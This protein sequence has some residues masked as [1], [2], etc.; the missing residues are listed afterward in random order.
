MGDD[1]DA[2]LEQ[3]VDQ[4]EDTVRQMLP[5][6]RGVLKGLGAAAIGG[7]AVGGA[8]G[9]AAGQSAAG[10]IGTES[11]P[12]DVEAASVGAQ[13]VST[14]SQYN[15]RMINVANNPYNAPKQGNGV[16]TQAVQQ[17]IDDLNGGPGV[18]V[19]PYWVAVEGLDLT[20]TEGITL[21]APPNSGPSQTSTVYNVAD[22]GG[23]YWAGSQDG[24]M[25]DATGAEGLTICCDIVTPTS[26]SDSPTPS[27]GV[28]IARSSQANYDA[29][30]HTFEDAV[31]A[32]EFTQSAVYNVNREESY[33]AN[34]VFAVQTGS[35]FDHAADN[36]A[37]VVSP[38]GTIDPSVKSMTRWEYIGC[39]FYC[40]SESNPSIRATHSA[41]EH[42]FIGNHYGAV[43][44]AVE[45]DT[46]GGP[47]NL[48]WTFL[49]PRHERQSGSSGP[50]LR[51]TGG[52]DLSGIRL[53]DGK[54]DSGGSGTYF[55]DLTDS[56]GGDVRNF[57][58]DG[59]KKTSFVDTD[60][61]RFDSLYDS[62]IN[63]HGA[64]GGSTVE[65]TT[66]NVRNEFNLG[67]GWSLN[68][69]GAEFVAGNRRMGQD[70][71]VY[72][73]AS[74]LSTIQGEAGEV[75]M[76]DGTGT[77]PFGL[78]FW[79]PSKASGSGNWVATADGTVFGPN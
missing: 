52:N 61:M 72:W 58:F 20:E 3:R 46:S 69:S 68:D 15:G 64:G 45:F 29:R 7:A 18:I 5:N 47:T 65:I 28:L 77:G 13:S 25:V 39:D 71:H 27:I 66:D 53:I 78:A 76:H 21:S 73:S 49:D 55:V 60:G 26:T 32:G 4:L 51:K 67:V 22:R 16:G 37:G 6:R 9:G 23:L 63:V 41:G 38:F 31:F 79:D 19:F 8:T 1:S 70:H 2:Q 33:V 14:G 74:D 56:S 30:G 59:G 54:Y 48:A 35:I 12:V 34:S 75:V 40:Y 57:Y 11:E 43:D 42:H 24:V 62:Q 44:A 17:A 50:F 36:S 10:Q